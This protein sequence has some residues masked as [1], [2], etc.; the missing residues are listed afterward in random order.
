MKSARAEVSGVLALTVAKSKIS[1]SKIEVRPVV[2]SSLF[3][4]LF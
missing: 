3:E 4:Q 1:F 2:A